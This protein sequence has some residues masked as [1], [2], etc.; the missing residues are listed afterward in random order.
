MLSARVAVALLA[1][2]A[3]LL[4]VENAKWLMRNAGKGREDPDEIERLLQLLRHE[5]KVD[6]SSIKRQSTSP[7]PEVK[8]TDTA[9]PRVIQKKNIN[10]TST[11]ILYTKPNT[12][13]DFTRSVDISRDIAKQAET[14]EIS[15]RLTENP[16][17]ATCSA[18]PSMDSYEEGKKMLHAHKKKRKHEFTPIELAANIKLQQTTGVLEFYEVDGSAI[19]STVN[20]VPILDTH[21]GKFSI[22]KSWG[23][24]KLW[25]NLHW[26]EDPQKRHHETKLPNAIPE[27]PPLWVAVAYNGWTN[28]GNVFTCD[29]ALTTGACLWEMSN[30]KTPKKKFK[31]VLALCDSWCRGYFHFAHEHLPRV[32]VVYQALIDDPEIVITVPTNRDFIVS[33]FHDVLGIDKSRLVGTTTASADVLLYPQ[34]QP[35]GTMWSHGL[36]LL[37]RIVFNKHS[38]IGTNAPEKFLIVLAER[39]GGKDGKSRN[40]TNYQAVKQQL[41]DA[42]YPTDR[43][44]VFES[45]LNKV[46]CLF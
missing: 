4:S 28:Q 25:K 18:P 29:Y 21:G 36:M 17:P 16:Q 40:P 32:A 27:Q 46:C 7:V 26:I 12:K 2:F 14:W 22:F 20:D 24:R 31:K 13:L 38:I 42:K 45:S 30:Y 37:R 34:P 41:A 3:I 1:L 5:A 23:D 39:A 44:V 10:N 6:L 9:K 19:P 35:C 43:D 11:P 15:I 33:Y 8:P